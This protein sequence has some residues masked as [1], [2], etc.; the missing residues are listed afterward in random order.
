MKVITS[1]KATL[2]EGFSENRVALRQINY[3]SSAASVKKTVFSE[4][5]WWMSVDPRRVADSDLVLSY[6]NFHL[7]NLEELHFLLSNDSEDLPLIQTPEV[8]EN[9]FGSNYAQTLL[10]LS[11]D[12][13]DMLDYN[14]LQMVC[15]LF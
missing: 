9:R 2:L 5:C 1:E 3:F 8:G 14:T 6:V 13:F 15:V 10:T 4:I 11:F 12:T 7:M